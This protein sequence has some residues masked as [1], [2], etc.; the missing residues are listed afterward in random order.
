MRIPGRR[1]YIAASVLLVLM[2]LMHGFAQL[3]SR[4]TSPEGIAIEER[5]RGYH[6][7][8][9]FGMSP[10]LLDL[11]DNLGF[12]VTITLLWLGLMGL[13]VAMADPSARVLRR[14]I[15][16][17]LIA[18]AA[19][20]ASQAHFRVLPSLGPLVLVVALLLVSLLRQLTKPAKPARQEP[21]S[22]FSAASKA[23]PPR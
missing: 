21:T 15:L 22:A 4:A 23:T 8:F 20:A 16:V 10:S 7:S 2:G 18:G 13:A 5:M 6:V 12:S 11:S 14:M 17:S 1:T 3:N 19:L 9:G